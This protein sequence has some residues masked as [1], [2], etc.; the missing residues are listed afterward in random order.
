MHTRTVKDQPRLVDDLVDAGA[1][2]LVVKEENGLAAQ[3]QHLVLG[4]EADRGDH[5]RVRGEGPVDE[6]VGGV[7]L[8][9]LLSDKVHGGV[10]DVRVVE[11]GDVVPALPVDVHAVRKRLHQHDAVAG[12]AVL[13]QPGQ[14]AVGLQEVP[15]HDHLVLVALVALVLFEL[16]H[17]FVGVHWTVDQK[18]VVRVLGERHPV[19][20]QRLLELFAAHQ[21]QQ[22]V[23]QRLVVVDH[24][25]FRLPVDLRQVAGDHAHVG[26]Q[27]D[28]L[29]VAL[30][31]EVLLHREQLL[32]LLGQ[33]RV[34]AVRAHQ[35]HVVE[36][37][38]Q[39][40]ALAQRERDTNEPRTM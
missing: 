10:V 39:Q 32:D 17:R 5:V 1:D 19:L 35:H 11:D 9:G 40:R 8:D 28:H 12:H 6:V 21:E 16:G 18:H 23:A 15:I 31:H 3:L 4:L 25:V 34:D 30:R 24:H 13:Q 37:D 2:A 20:L 22:V 27:A 26:L 14:A 38:L 7:D 29:H 33:L 36:V